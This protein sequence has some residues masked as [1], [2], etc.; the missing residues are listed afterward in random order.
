MSVTDGTSSRLLAGPVASTDRRV[1]AMSAAGPFDRLKGLAATLLR[2]HAVVVLLDDEPSDAED[3]SPAIT[4]FARLVRKRGPTFVADAMSQSWPTDALVLGGLGPV[5][6]GGV[7]L[8]LADGSVAGC[9][10]VIAADAREWARDEEE[11]LIGIA[12][13]IASR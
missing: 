6:C 13:E 4:A 10:C 1:P 2:A 8:A 9:V 7:P 11:I 3:A 12:G 5:A